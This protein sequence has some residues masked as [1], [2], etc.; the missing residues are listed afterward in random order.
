MN[1]STEYIGEEGEDSW[2]RMV[3][4]GKLVNPYIGFVSQ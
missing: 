4:R 2:A 1:K 3:I